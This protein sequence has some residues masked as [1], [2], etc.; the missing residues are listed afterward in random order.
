MDGWKRSD[1]IGRMVSAGRFG[2]VIIP[3]V[4]EAFFRSMIL[5]GGEELFVLYNTVRDFVGLV[6][7]AFV[8]ES[9][10][11]S[12]TITHHRSIIFFLLNPWIYYGKIPASTLKYGLENPI[13]IKNSIT[14]YIKQI[15]D[16]N[17]I[18]F[19]HHSG[20]GTNNL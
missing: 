13:N 15:N 9:A 19:I 10:V 14:A 5:G 3:S 2:G 12:P 20:K 18:T 11:P 17:L 8:R 4:P 7:L 6:W 1:V 16:N